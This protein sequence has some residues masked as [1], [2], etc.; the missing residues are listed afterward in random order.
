M[1]NILWK[2]IVVSGVSAAADEI[3]WTT[4]PEGQIYEGS[5]NKWDCANLT[6]P[7]DR[8]DP[9]KGNVTSFV[10]R[11][12]ASV[13]GKKSS[14]GLAGGPG[15]S[16]STFVPMFDY[17]MML[18]PSITSFLV[19]ARGIGLSS[20]LTNCLHA[21]PY[22]DP[23]NETLM[24]M[25]EECNQE[26]I[27]ADAALYPY[28]TTLDAAMDLK[29]VMEA[30]NPDTISVFAASCGTFLANTL[31][32]LIEVDVVVYDGPVTA[33]RWSM[34]VNA[35]M[36]TMVSLDT[37]RMCVDESDICKS[38]LG[39]TANIPQMTKD[40]IIDG[41]LPCLSQLSWLAAENG[42]FLTSMYNNFMNPNYNKAL[43]G[44]FWYRLFRCSASDVEQLNFFHA[45]R[46]AEMNSWE[47]SDPLVYSQG[48]AIN[49]GAADLFSNAG[50]DAKSYDKV[51]E[52]NV[53]NFVVEGG[54]L[55]VSFARSESNWPVPVA[56]EISRTYAN[57]TA[58]LHI[59]VGTLDAN[60][61]VGQAYWMRQRMSSDA[62]VSIHIVPYAHHGI[63]DPSNMCAVQYV[64][65]LM[66]LNVN[67]DPACL[68]TSV[69]PPDWDGSDAATQSNALTW[70]GTSDLWNNGYVFDEQAP[71]TTSNDDDCNF[72]QSDVT[73]LIVGIC[74]PLS[75][76][77]IVLFAIVVVQCYS[78]G[79]DK[80]KLMRSG[81]AA[82]ESH[83][84]I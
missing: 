21:P 50:A 3:F 63:V 41:S 45:A 36:Q 4:C 81:G 1:F 60:T 19:D 37:M 42:N 57:P 68:E 18:D 30:V 44:P 75:V 82:S 10:R 28:F 47:H 23:Y 55:T 34:E 79:N 64:T 83:S 20:S 6:F 32:Q 71:D 48:Y 9:A 25:Q 14:W 26:M 84:Q 56:H 49:V 12:Y 2:I 13:P 69:P 72:V 58:P 29:G 59:L 46:Q 65:D 73:K 43:Q 7:M 16:T 33:N 39:D 52:D 76:I 17:F 53:R 66:A 74:V 54:D 51:V 77:I 38:Y 11:G 67:A 22:L 31:L 35:E 15:Y 5:M 40:A 70:F 62:D 8:D 78:R 27:S 80:D 61:P 24:A